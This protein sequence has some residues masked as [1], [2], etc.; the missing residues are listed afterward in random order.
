MAQLGFRAPGMSNH[1]D[2][3]YKKLGTLKKK[4]TI[5][6]SLFFY[7]ISIIKMYLSA[8]KLHFSFRTPILLPRVAT[9]LFISPATPLVITETG[10][11][12]KISAYRKETGEGLVERRKAWALIQG[13]ILINRDSLVTNNSLW[14]KCL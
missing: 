5:I 7:F 8:K 4:I 10:Q 12:W 3:P 2:H 9:L 6:Y 14:W 11:R 1:N 13:R